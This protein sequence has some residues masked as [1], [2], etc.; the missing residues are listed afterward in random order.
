VVEHDAL[1]A[2]VR[3][4]LTQDGVFLTSTPDRLM[5]TEHL[6][7]ENP[8]HVRELSL[9]EFRE[10][11]GGAFEH[12]SY[13]GQAVA[14]GSLVQP[15]EPGERGRTDV[16]ALQRDGERWVDH[17]AYAPTYFIAA[18]S[19]APLP[20]LPTHSLLVDVDIEIVR[21]A[22]R[23][24]FE[25]EDRT[26]QSLADL[27][28]AR[29]EWDAA[30]AKARAEIGSL[31][32]ERDAARD[33][34]DEAD[35]EIRALHD[36]AES[37]ESQLGKAGREIGSLH[38]SVE[39]LRFDVELAKTQRSAARADARRAAEE[40]AVIRGSRVHRAALAYYR[41][42]ERTAPAGSRRRAAYGRAGRTA[43]RVLRA[44]LRRRAPGSTVEVTPLAVPVSS[45]PLVSIVIPVHG[46]WHFTEMCLRSLAGH[47]T[48]ASFEVVVVD[49]A[50]PDDTRLRLGGVA[51]VRVVELDENLG[52][53]GAVNAGIAAAVGEF[54]VLLNNDTEVRD[55]WL[56]ALVETAAQERVGLVGSKLVY[57][58]GRLQEAGGII[59]SN[60]GGANYGRFDDPNLPRY[61]V[62]R[63]VDYC[64]GTAIIVRRD[65]LEE[66]G[67]LDEE[68]APAYYDDVDLAFALRERGLRVVY[69]PRAVV[70]HHEGVSHGT[71]GAV[72]IKR[73]QEINR[74]KILAKWGHRLVDH[75][76][77]D[78]ALLQA[79]AR[80]QGSKGVLV[81]I[82]DHVPRPDED[83][84]S[85]RTFAFLRTLRRL[86]WYVVFVPDNGQPGDVWGDRLR[87]EGIEV[88]AGP[89]P[90][91]H[92]LSS[93]RPEVR[94]VIGARVTVAWPYVG[95]ARRVL[96]GVPF[97]FDTVD[98]HHLREG[99]EAELSGDPAQ[100]AR[101]AATRRQELGFVMAADETI[102]VSPFE[103]D[104]LAKV[105]PEATVCVV[106]NV[107]ERRD[108]GP[109]VDG[110]TGMLFVG[111]FAHPPNADAVRWFVDSVLPLVR[112]EVPDAVL[113]VVGRGAPEDLLAHVEQN[114]GVE[115][116]G[117][118]PS[119]DDV[120]AESRVSI[121][122]L[123]YGSGVKGKVGE[124][125]SHGVPVVGT[126]VAMEGMHIEHGVSGWIADG[127]ADFAAGVVR[128]LRDE[129]LWT[130]LSDG[131]RAHVDE[132]LGDAAF[133]RSV[134]EAL[135]RVGLE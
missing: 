48:S 28:G 5:Y 85:V 94:A 93:L 80:R 124:A 131:G 54:V 99:R 25:A 50:S 107:H 65:I 17:G 53:V 45:S 4:V 52:F 62:Q 89:E 129:T 27:E 84:G 37:L 18:A 79:A 83:S 72:G 105:L 104:L 113:R 40:L 91:D 112:S 31:T 10:L 33:R 2:G 98:L 41:V 115:I 34:L 96:P 92:F 51:G 95:M 12:V 32:E 123:R 86:G 90:V 135:A 121:A 60:A 55:G 67:G 127:A 71:D 35:A 126:R 132:V 11:L 134:V 13:W 111:G 69:E 110:R 49:D 56:D 109:A 44:L 76:P 102:V 87:E 47:V 1:V 36:S 7:Q 81:F 19:A 57:P 15:V 9:D 58:D 61:N 73:Y 59:F 106:P 30:S 14:T 100:L 119:L 118:L 130:V 116:L 114:P 75:Y 125:L 78:P 66:L 68:L 22:Q 82:D 101:A 120:Y 26:R 103:A 117:W 39:G 23:A 42:V 128:V 133:E 38:A 70:V 63:D 97:L 74:K 77:Q 8:H 6:H 20:D 122:P 64:S 88:F 43:V 46:K 3:R 108:A 21:S 24:M 16:V 29:Q